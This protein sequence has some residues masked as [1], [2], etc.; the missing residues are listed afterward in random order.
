MLL[1]RGVPR[2][3][4]EMCH[5]RKVKCD[6]VT[7]LAQGNHQCS[8]CRM[9]SLDCYI[10]EVTSDTTRKH[11]YLQVSASTSLP[12]SLNVSQTT[13]SSTLDI[14][15]GVASFLDG[16]FASTIP[17]TE[18]PLL[19]DNWLFASDMQL[20]A[21]TTSGNILGVIG[22]E[23]ILNQAVDAYFQY[24]AVCM[25]VLVEE[26]FRASYSAN[27]CS[28]ALVLA[29]ACR[30]IGYMAVTDK[31]MLQ[32][33]I[34]QQFRHTILSAKDRFGLDEIEGLAIMSG[35]HF[36]GNKEE[37]FH[38]FTHE[39][40]VRM[41]LKFGLNSR[42]EASRRRTLLFW[43]IYAL[44]AFYCADQHCMSSL[45]DDD[46]D[47]AAI[48]DS[49]GYL[50][51]ILA[52]ARIC[53]EISRRF[54]SAVAKR[55]GVDATTIF[56]IYDRLQELSWSRPAHLQWREDQPNIQRTFIRML[57]LACYMS[58]EDSL[59]RCGL[60]EH[61]KHTTEGRAALIKV[62]AETL[63]AWD[64]VVSMSEIN[65]A[66]YDSSPD[67]LRNITAGCCVWGATKASHE[68]YGT[69]D[70]LL[71]ENYR[72]RIR[73][74]RDAIASATCHHDTQEILDRLKEHFRSLNFDL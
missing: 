18:T 26:E 61:S 19:S 22:S 32:R 69:K 4:C 59:S 43:H 37:T 35:Y 15:P 24:M 14:S 12:S 13:N 52:L 29:V 27:R 16:I 30:G 72:Q 34:G 2:I 55:A 64:G 54:N 33:R 49:Q 50:D 66:F 39:A 65:K 5:R 8:Q 21:L 28:D 46:V 38:P 23:D 73:K 60:D 20:P 9:R 57:E 25:P 58:L 62:D 17:T 71:I 63:R 36:G 6:R 45:H 68:V 1:K 53:R 74:L 40:L 70:M 3:S 47:A 44:D 11:P 41:V 42:N 10:S 7:Q 48:M 51:A 56:N 31:F 67:V